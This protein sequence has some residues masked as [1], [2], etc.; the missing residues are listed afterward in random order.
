[1]QAMKNAKGLIH[2]VLI[3][4]G[5]GGL[6]DSKF[7]KYLEPRP[8]YIQVSHLVPVELLVGASK[9]AAP[10]NSNS[11]GPSDQT[12]SERQNYLLPKADAHVP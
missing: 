9:H 4:I 11:D 7:D 8:S 3:E 2:I 5:F 6:T 1:M 10:Y 12:E